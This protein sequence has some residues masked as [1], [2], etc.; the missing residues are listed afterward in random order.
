M[1]ML[2][3]DAVGLDEWKGWR[4]SGDGCEHSTVVLEGLL[5]LTGG[6]VWTSRNDSDGLRGHYEGLGLCGKFRRR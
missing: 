1:T 3:L 4:N 5:R 2:R 6:R